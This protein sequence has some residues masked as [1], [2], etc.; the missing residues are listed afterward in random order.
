MLKLPEESNHTIS[1][2]KVLLETRLPRSC[3]NNITLI[4]DCRWDRIQRLDLVV[5][6]LSI[7]NWICHA[8]NWSL[9][10]NKLC[11]YNDD[12][13][14]RTRSLHPPRHDSTTNL[15]TAA[16]I[17]LKP[18][19]RISLLEV[20]YVRLL[21]CKYV[22]LSLHY[23]E[24]LHPSQCRELFQK[25]VLHTPSNLALGSLKWVFLFLDPFSNGALITAFC[26]AGPSLNRCQACWKNL[27]GCI[28]HEEDL[29]WLWGP[30]HD[31]VW[32]P[33]GALGRDGLSRFSPH[34]CIMEKEEL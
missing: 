30:W 31:R 20:R 34:E 13:R 15:R 2:L 19:L 17:L 21:L 4:T 23:H 8:I 32:L 27:V 6:L 26:V 7:R 29:Y 28:D 33:V 18:E 12:Y 11:L 1:P 16:D 22:P 3:R 9:H 10:Q 5:N 24:V 14:A 25:Y